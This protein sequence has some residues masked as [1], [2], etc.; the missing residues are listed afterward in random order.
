M[1]TEEKVICDDYTCYRN[2]LQCLMRPAIGEGSFK[3]AKLYIILLAWPWTVRIFFHCHSPKIFTCV[4][5]FVIEEYVYSAE[6]CCSIPGCSWSRL[7]HVVM[8][9]RPLPICGEYV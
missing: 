3:S 4:C 2:Y 6:C 5:L 9:E 1:H 8:T 7:V